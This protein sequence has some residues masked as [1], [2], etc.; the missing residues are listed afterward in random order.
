MMANYN[1]GQNNMEQ[2]PHLPNCEK[3]HLVL[4]KRSF[5]RQEEESVEEAR[6]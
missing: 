3:S 6:G 1:L 4:V 5:G 2:S